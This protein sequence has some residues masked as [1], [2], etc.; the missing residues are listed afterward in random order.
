MSKGNPFLALRLASDQQEALRARAAAHGMTLSHLIRKVL[1][2]NLDHLDDLPVAEQITDARIRQKQ[3]A[4]PRRPRRP[5]RPARLRSAIDSLE[6]L[7]ADYEDWQ[8]NVPDSLQE[9]ATAT[10]LTEAIENLQQALDLLNAIAPPLG[11]GRD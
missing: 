4:G 2:D 9:T 3:A 1:A 8:A 11:F 5:S 6:D 10:A 7:L